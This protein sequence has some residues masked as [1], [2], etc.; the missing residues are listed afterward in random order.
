MG[1]AEVCRGGSGILR[2]E[3][4]VAVALLVRPGTNAGGL[5]GHPASGLPR[6][7]LGDPVSPSGMLTSVSGGCVTNITASGKANLLSDS[8]G[9]GG[10][11]SRSW[12][13]SPAVSSAGP[14][15]RFWGAPFPGLLQIREAASLRQLKGTHRSFPPPLR[16][17]GSFKDS[18]PPPLPLTRTP[19]PA[20]GLTMTR[21]DLPHCDP[22]CHPTHRVS[23]PW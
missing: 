20:S 15:W 6:S 19:V 21:D 17:R 8:P 13:S 23:F 2:W 7:F 22:G 1:R 4:P 5:V 11:R 14:L 16:H 12:A 3:C 10:P 9:A 18:D